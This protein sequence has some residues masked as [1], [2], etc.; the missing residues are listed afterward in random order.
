MLC[1]VLSD[2]VPFSLKW[3]QKFSHTGTMNYFSIV[4]YNL[5]NFQILNLYKIEKISFYGSCF[6]WNAEFSNITNNGSTYFQYPCYISKWRSQST[7]YIEIIRINI[8]VLFE[9]VSI[10]FSI[11]NENWRPIWRDIKQL[12]E[13]FLQNWLLYSISYRFFLQ[14]S[15]L[16]PYFYLKFNRKIGFFDQKMDFEVLSLKNCS[17]A[18]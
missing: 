17:T 5:N 1:S 10:D 2:S 16:W 8:S 6:F 11:S 9:V 15:W 4:S 13:N 18:P 3:R 7:L 14:Q 12:N